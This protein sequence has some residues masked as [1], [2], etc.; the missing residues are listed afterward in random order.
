[1]VSKLI[2]VFTANT[3]RLVGGDVGA[4]RSAVSVVNG[5]PAIL[6][7]IHGQLDSVTVCSVSTDRISA[8]RLIRFPCIHRAAHLRRSL[9][10]FASGVEDGHCR[11]NL[12]K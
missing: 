3:M 4:I 10:P 5:E 9:S 6:T 2:Q 8:M 12:K 7:W 11:A 1:V